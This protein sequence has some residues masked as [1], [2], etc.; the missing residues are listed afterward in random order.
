MTIAKLGH[1]DIKEMLKNWD[2]WG[3]ED[4]LWAIHSDPTKKGNLWDEGEFFE[5]GKHE[6]D[7]VCAC[8]RCSI[9]A[10]AG[11][12]ISHPLLRASAPRHPAPTL[13]R[14]QAW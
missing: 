7:S 12:S 14:K 5:S 13:P 9:E 8:R 4:P 6:I 11:S 2:S 3:N 1:M 10:G